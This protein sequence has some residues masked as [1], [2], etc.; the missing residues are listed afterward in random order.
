MADEQSAV[1]ERVQAFKRLQASVQLTP[2]KA[3][4]WVARIRAER[5]GWRVP[6]EE[7]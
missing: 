3:D 7:A 5:D 4:A 1:S 2:E 6:G